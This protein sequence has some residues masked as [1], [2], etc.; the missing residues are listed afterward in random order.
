MSIQSVSTLIFVFALIHTFLASKVTHLSHR[1]PEGSTRRSILHLI[2]E[3]EVVFGFWA[4]VFLSYMAFTE[5]PKA[6]ITYI[7]SLKFTEPLFVFV[8]MVVCAT[9]PILILSRELMSGFSW[10]IRKS[11]R[12]PATQA[13]IFVLLGIGPILGSFITE[14]AAMTVIALLLRAMVEK[15]KP[16]TLYVLVAVLF[17]NVSIGGSLTPFAAPPIL[18]VAS[19]WGWDLPFVFS[20]FGIRSVI[21]SFINSALFV[22]IFWRDIGSGIKS[23][24]VVSRENQGASRQ[25]PAWIKSVHLVFLALIVLNHTHSNLFMGL[26]LF[27]LGFTAAT[28]PYQEALRMRESLLVAF[29]LGGLM[30][31]GEFQKWWLQPL[32][33]QMSEVTLFLGATGLTAVTDNAALTY[34]GSQ[35]EG[36]AEVSRYALVAGA[37]AG[38]GLTVLANAPNP[39]GYSI[40]VNKFPGGALNH[41]KFFFI[42]LGPTLVAVLFLGPWF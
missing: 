18:M 38:G 2:G 21:A 14:P 7:E 11:L 12:L 29:F 33:A 20:Q 5:A 16:T 42:A 10:I 30:V 9:R 3:V 17:V 6:A 13:D 25:V 15:V 32:L 34:L 41:L 31:F 36:L 28:K 35:V 23:L 22:A 27:F 26:F 39:A 40:L 37:L 24:D 4:A 8:I 1:F 19:K